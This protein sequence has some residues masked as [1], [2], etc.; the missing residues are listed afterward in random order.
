VKIYLTLRADDDKTVLTFRFSVPLDDLG[1]LEQRAH[2]D[3]IYASF[4]T[5]QKADPT[6]DHGIENDIL[7]LRLDHTI[8]QTICSLLSFFVQHWHFFDIDHF[9]RWNRTIKTA[10]LEV[11][12]RDDDR[13]K[14]ILRNTFVFCF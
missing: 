4:T 7:C 9:K 3:K 12:L 8:D 10:E 14:Y 13:C 5:Y 11:D 1:R 6:Y 2:L